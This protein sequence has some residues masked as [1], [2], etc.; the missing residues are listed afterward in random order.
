MELTQH[1]RKVL[2]NQEPIDKYGAHFEY[3]DLFQ[4]LV[5]VK[6]QLDRKINTKKIKSF[7]RE[8]RHTPINMS[9]NK[10]RI[11]HSSRSSSVNKNPRRGISSDFMKIYKIYSPTNKQK[12]MTPEKLLGSFK[13][14]SSFFGKRVFKK[15]MTNS[16][17]F[18]LK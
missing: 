1:N 13:V 4:R 8:S 9:A 15:R 10:V 16:K 6:R 3:Q 5:L 7:D 11:K 18:N 17:V 2:E 14:P 12:I